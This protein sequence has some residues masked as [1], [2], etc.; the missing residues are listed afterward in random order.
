MVRWS[1]GHT[2]LCTDH[3][4]I[5]PCRPFPIDEVEILLKIRNGMIIACL[6]GCL[7]FVH[8]CNPGSSA[9]TKQDAAF[10]RKMSQARRLIISRKRG[11]A[12]KLIREAV[13]IDP[14]RYGYYDAAVSL[15][16]SHD[17]HKECIALLS[18]GIPHVHDDAGLLSKSPD[19]FHRSDLYA[20]LGDE[21]LQIEVLGEAEKAYKEA[22]RLD[23]KNAWAYNDL[24]YMYADKGIKLRQ[25]LVLTLQ[26]MD[27]KPN[28]GMIV[29]S[30]GWVYFKLGDKDRAIEYLTKAVDLVPDDPE[31]RYHLGMAYE[32]SGNPQGALV[33]Y[34][35]ALRIDPSHKMA[36]SHRRQLLANL[37][38]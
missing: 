7:L 5:R 32:S 19:D 10:D 38:K 27:M 14:S 25:A 22:I 28:E 24:G 4:T 1:N 20:K 12:A 31:L 15:L 33:E 37:S 35:K 13:G 34:A 2:A 9:S 3:Q 16:A 29:D 21:Y 18:Q 26:A 17:M 11:P 36:K 23:K 30:V 8:G 6:C